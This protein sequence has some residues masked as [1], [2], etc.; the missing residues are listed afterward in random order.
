MPT[1]DR[2]VLSHFP[3]EAGDCGTALLAYG[4]FAEEKAR[5]AEQFAAQNRTMPTNNQERNWIRSLT[6]EYFARRLGD[7]R[8]LLEAYAYNRKDSITPEQAATS[9]MISELS[10]LKSRI[11]SEMRDVGAT[12]AFDVKSGG[13]FWKQLRP[14]FASAIL[15]P[16]VLA[17][18]IGF[19]VAYHNHLPY[20]DDL[21]NRLQESFA[22][23]GPYAVP[24]SGQY[25][26]SK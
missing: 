11:Y 15:S 20:W 9:R 5:W 26:V 25:A 16:I 24:K 7:A 8:T 18:L 14:A 23:A 2:E 13:T 3:G 17:L 1:T 12:I 4:L 10:E 21:K 6:P 22:T 19:A